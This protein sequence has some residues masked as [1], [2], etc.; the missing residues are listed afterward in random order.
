MKN[1]N[2]LRDVK[3]LTLDEKYLLKVVM[4]IALLVPWFGCLVSPLIIAD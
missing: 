2:L 3:D 4:A 1:I